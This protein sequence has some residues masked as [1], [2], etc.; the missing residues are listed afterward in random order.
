VVT[1][2]GGAIGASVA[3]RLSNDGFT[4]A[5]TDLEVSAAERTA[6]SLGSAAAFGCDVRVESDVQTL[7]DAIGRTLGE[8]WLVVNSAGVFFEHLL[9]DLSE[10]GWDFIIDVNLKGTFLICKTFLPA[11]IKAHTGCIIN[12]GST[13]G[14]HGAEGR[15]AYCASK[16]GVSLLTRALALDHAR[17]G[18]R[19]NCVCPGV[20]DTPMADW[21]TSDPEKFE[22]WRS[23]IPAHRAGMPDDVAGAVSFLA[24]SDADYVHGALLVVDGAASA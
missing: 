12:V 17:D 5:C 24:S 2:A 10:E 9:A 1:G 3:K 14:I 13:L 4:V 6:A 21:L 11:M 18:V 20:V 22:A 8:P 16:G 7:C 15:A 19:V 23:T